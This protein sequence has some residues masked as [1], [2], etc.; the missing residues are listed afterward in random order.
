MTEYLTSVGRGC[1]LI[2]NIGPDPTGAVP[3]AD[4]PAYA[5]F[6]AAW[7]ELFNASRRLSTAPAPLH[8]APHATSVEWSAADQAVS[9]TQG[10]IVLQEDLSAG[11]HIA[12]FN[13]S[14]VSATGAAQALGSPRSTLGHK[15]IVPFNLSSAFDATRFVVDLAMAPGTSTTVTISRAEVYDWRDARFVDWDAVLSD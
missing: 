11:Q 12:S 10:A 5:A 13:V 8:A 1:N 2:L 14:A 3:S 9:L 7:Q 6:G 4:V 15:A